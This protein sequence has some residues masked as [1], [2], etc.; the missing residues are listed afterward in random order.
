MSTDFDL[1][2]IGAGPGGYVSAIRAAQ[3][4]LKTAIIEKRELG[5]ACLNRGCIPT[6]S[7][8]H[9]SHLYREMKNSEKFGVFADNV[10]YD[11]AKIFER[12]NDVVTQLTSGVEQLL[13]TNEVTMIE[14]TGQILAQGCVAITNDGETKELTTK[15]VLIA[16][17][18][19]AARPPI[20]GIDLQ[21]VITSEEIFR[22]PVDYKKLVIIGGGVIGIEFATVFSS[23]GCE[24]TIIEALDRVLATMDKEISQ[25]LS[26]I[27][28]KRGIKLH[29]SSSV[30]RIEQKDGELLCHFESKG[31]ALSAGGE[32]VLVAV[33][34]RAYLE[35]L[36]AEGVD[37][38]TERG[39]VVDGNFQTSLPGVYAVGDVVHG[40]I[41]L[42][43]V[44]SAQGC[45][46]VAHIAGH[47]PEIDLG[48]IT[49]CVYTDPEI[50]SVGITEAQAK[51]QGIEV[52]TGKFV[53]NGNGK[54]I[55][56]AQERGFIKLIFTADETATILGAQLMCSRATDLVSEL[57]T[58]VVN[59]L[60]V[61]DMNA[62]VR[63]HPTFS[64]GISEAAEQAMG[65]AIHVAPKMKL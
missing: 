30:S 28:K 13:R 2:I 44:A 18:S 29:T 7:L 58:A 56:E 4:G 39:I 27:L 8:I 3:F 38:R 12:K 43:H 62:L 51:A 59:K 40:G 10:S 36:L 14:G 50:A 57:A 11:I 16:T 17:G 65:I 49:S 25:N 31:K 61:H 47:K 46:A 41:Q 32:A 33:G 55:I 63:P 45:N 53:M 42:A 6:K 15:N 60:S 34:R 20:E 5:G 35:G 26:M 48:A 1:I 52:K 54:S 23:L 21:G 37:I 19:V 64:E 22:N 24:V 9:S